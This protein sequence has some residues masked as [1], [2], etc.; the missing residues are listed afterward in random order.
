MNPFVCLF[1]FFPFDDQ[2]CKLQFGSWAFDRSK[3]D[4]VF[5]RNESGTSP[6]QVNTEWELL[7]FNATMKFVSIGFVLLSFDLS[8]FCFDLCLI[9]DGGGRSSRDLDPKRHIMWQLC[10]P[11]HFWRRISFFSLQTNYS[12]CKYPYTSVLLEVKLRRRFYYYMVNLVVPCSLIAVMVLL[13]FILPPES[14][15]RISLGITVL[16]AMAI[17]QELT[18]EKL[19]VEST[20][21]PLLG[22]RFW[23]WLRY[24]YTV[25]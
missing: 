25:S 17:F 11:Q 21:T 7:A 19:P 16:M 2:T 22:E 24:R 14:G 4:M 13:S 8:L 1:R 5:D 18:S 12:C 3:L 9:Q 23:L 20:H 6:Y 10:L 15:E